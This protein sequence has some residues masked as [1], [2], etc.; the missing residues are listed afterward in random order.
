MKQILENL[1][2]AEETKVAL[3]E[4]FDKKVLAEAVILAES[5]E[6]EYEEYMLA[7]MTEMKADLEDTMNAY[8]EKVVE[9]FVEE[10]TFA[11]DEAINSE[12]YEAVL[13][14]FNSLM[15]TTGVEIAQIAEAKEIEDEA[16]VAEAE[17]ED[18]S[19]GEM[20]DK[21]MAENIELKTKNAELLK[22]GLVKES[23]EDM[24]AV[25]KDKFLKLA[26]VVEFDETNPVDFITKMDTLVEA[27]KEAKVAP[28][29]EKVEVEEEIVAESVEVK[30]T[31]TARHLY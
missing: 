30:Y 22:T 14:G 13:E 7:Q 10:N 26:S 1:E 17:E 25:Q 5:K 16:I 20:A 2:L 23:M 11:M 24:T 21:L 15:I 29:A 28:V 9:T 6:A 31:A 27:V 3:Q 8:L 4:S 12:K 19:I 18:A